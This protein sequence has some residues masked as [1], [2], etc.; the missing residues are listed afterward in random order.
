MIKI[1]KNYHNG[2]ASLYISMRYLTIITISSI[3]IRENGN[4]FKNLQNLD[5]EIRWQLRLEFL[6]AGWRKWNTFIN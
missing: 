2:V 6:W 5:P 4:P 3:E 1:A